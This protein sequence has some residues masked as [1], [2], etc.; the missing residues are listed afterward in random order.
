LHTPSTAQQSPR[1]ASSQPLDQTPVPPPIPHATRPK[2]HNAQAQPVPGSPY[3]AQSTP[4][5][6][7]PQPAPAPV[8]QQ[9]SSRYIRNRRP[10]RHR[11]APPLPRVL[12][13]LAPFSRSE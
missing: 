13:G 2:I 10:H 4:Q 9:L 6:Q 8:P 5:A 12:R 1:P 11:R 7:A 3:P